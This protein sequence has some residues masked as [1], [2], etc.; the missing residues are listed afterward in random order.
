MDIYTGFLSR[1]TATHSQSNCVE[2]Y[3]LIQTPLTSGRT[4][5]RE[6][7]HLVE[8][9][10][11]LPVRTAF[12]IIDYFKCEISELILGNYS[13]KTYKNNT[14]LSLSDT[15]RLRVNTQDLV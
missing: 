13:A 1:K 6:L 7:E 12:E 10:P 3:H 8:V 15:E 2:F 5:K 4:I 9:R 14:I 11:T